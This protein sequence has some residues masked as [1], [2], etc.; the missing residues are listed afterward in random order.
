MECQNQTFDLASIKSNNLYRCCHFT[1][2]AFDLAIFGVRNAA[3]I[4]DTGHHDR[5]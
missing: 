2:G 1:L 3:H 5:V 4:S